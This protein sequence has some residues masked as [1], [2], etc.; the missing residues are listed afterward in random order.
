MTPI[1]HFVSLQS[2][3]EATKEEAKRFVLTCRKLNTRLQHLR[4]CSDEQMEPVLQKI[5]EEFRSLPTYILA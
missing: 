5:E 3:L 2:R 1:E 4:G